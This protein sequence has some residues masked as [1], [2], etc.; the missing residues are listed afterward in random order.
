MY[1]ERL[2]LDFSRQKK[3][4]TKAGFFSRTKK[5]LERDA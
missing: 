2:L 4:S 1:R 5:I 3:P